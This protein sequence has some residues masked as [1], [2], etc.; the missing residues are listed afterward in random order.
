MKE[1]RK[2]ERVLPLSEFYGGGRYG[3]CRGCVAVE[4]RARY[5]R[6]GARIR[7]RSKDYYRRHRGRILQKERADRAAKNSGTREIIEEERRA[8]KR[9]RDAGYRERHRENLR[10]KARAFARNRRAA[11]RQERESKQLKLEIER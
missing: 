11:R 2:C 1:C 10:A 5:L 8:A 4:N 6:D 7:A 3:R 9:S